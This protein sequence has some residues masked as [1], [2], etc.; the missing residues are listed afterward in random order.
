MILLT[1]TSVDRVGL[2]T[3]ERSIAGS[4]IVLFSRLTGCCIRG[5]VGNYHERSLS[6]DQGGLKCYASY[7]EVVRH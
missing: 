1:L 5:S 2:R 4:N 7:T 6:V 3:G